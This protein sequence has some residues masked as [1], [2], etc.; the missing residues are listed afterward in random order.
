MFGQVIEGRVSDPGAVQSALDEWARDVAPGAIGWLGS[1]G[2]VTD[3]GR[4]IALVRFESADA[5]RRNGARPE[6]DAWWSG[7]SQLFTDEPTFSDTEDVILDIVGEPDQAGFVQVMR[8]QGTD[9]DRARELMSQGSSEWAG[10]RPDILGSV[11]ALHPG[12]RYTMCI[13]FTNEAQAREGEQKEPPPALKA[14]MEEM[15]SMQSGPPEFF[16]LKQPWLHSPK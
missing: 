11:V 2:G 14:Q 8:G 10:F 12:G 9:S 13:Y 16:D 4:L 1:T 6:Q 15:N 5:A 7:M 3:D